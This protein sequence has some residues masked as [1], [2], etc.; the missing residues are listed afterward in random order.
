[1]EKCRIPEYTA[2]KQLL[3]KVKSG[4]LIK[5]QNGFYL[6]IPPQYQKL[7]R[8][9]VSYFAQKYFEFLNT[10]YYLGLHSAA[11]LYGAGD[12]R[13]QV[14]YVVVSGRI[15]SCKIKAQNIRLNLLS[16]KNFPEYGILK[17]KSGVSY[18]NVSSPA[19]TIADLI[20]YRQSLGGMSEIIETVV[21]LTNELTVQDA[22][23]V[24]SKYPYTSV[25][26]K[27]GYLL[28]RFDARKEII[29]VMYNCL[30]TRKHY[31]VLLESKRRE[32]A[33]SALNRWKVDQNTE[34]D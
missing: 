8:I 14:D 23:N 9:P 2:R 24:F 21:D 19:L 13:Y 16:S 33:G 5:L 29:K 22:E 26:Q 12:Q 11:L 6:I 15:P 3:A 1:L 31:P 10:N 28:E 25:L 4:E 7:K 32:S 18:V 34:I 20:H 17:K 27:A 30:K